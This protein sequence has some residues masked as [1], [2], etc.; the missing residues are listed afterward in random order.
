VETR[1]G[2]ITYSGSLL[3]TQNRLVASYG[4]VTLRI[5]S[6]SELELEAEVVTGRIESSLP[7]EGDVS[8]QEWLAT[9]NAP[10]AYVFVRSTNGWIRVEPSET[11]RPNGSGRTG[12]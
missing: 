6:E 8:G 3:G 9:L 12:G 7:W 11:M 4:G 10:T 1:V 5:P 2:N